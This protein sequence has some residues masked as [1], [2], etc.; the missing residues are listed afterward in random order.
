MKL[1][2]IHCMVSLQAKEALLRYQTEHQTTTQ[3]EAMN[4]LLVELSE[5]QQK[6]DENKKTIIA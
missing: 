4:M 3:D 6:K 2:R 5:K 1:E